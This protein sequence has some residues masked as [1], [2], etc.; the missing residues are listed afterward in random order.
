MKPIIYID[1]LLRSGYNVITMLTTIIAIGNSKG[2]RI[3]KLLLEESGI[4][5]D[6]EIKA[7]KN[8]LKIVPVKSSLKV[9]GDAALLSEMVLGNDWDRPEED[10]AWAGL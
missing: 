5:K 9:V 4:V 10:V 7:T 2:I 1:G 8:G 3:P 6:V